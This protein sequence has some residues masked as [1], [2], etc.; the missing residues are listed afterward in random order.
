MNKS[1]L[2]IPVIFLFGMLS[3]GDSGDEPIVDTF[4]RTMLLKNV[5]DSLMIPSFENFTHKVSE[6]EGAASVFNETPSIENL[7]ALRGQWLD[8]YMAWQHVSLFDI[9]KADEIDFREKTNLY[10][11]N[12]EAIEINI[13]SSSINLDLP[14]TF[15][16]QG[17]P[18][19][20]YLL[21]LPNMDDETLVSMY[22]GIDG[23][24]RRE[25]LS[26]LISI[27]VN[28]CSMILADWNQKRTEWILDAGNTATSLVN[29]LVNDYIL[30]YEKYIRTAKVG[31]PA[32]V[33]SNNVLPATTEAF[34]SKENSK[35]LLIE[36]LRASKNFFI[37]MH[38]TNGTGIEDYLDHLYLESG[39]TDVKNLI[40]SQYGIIFESLM[41]VGDN[42]S[43]QVQSDNVAMLGL[44]DAMQELVVFIKTDMTARLNVR[45]DFVDT[46]G[47]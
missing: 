24:G 45:I 18:A 14:S 15:D 6:L 23:Q 44:F 20:D 43:T 37:G 10:P 47:D 38:E 17:F 28:N 32:G 39:G 30:H 29:L 31:I 12:T 11:T 21:H 13:A 42:F 16:Q 46:D 33:F 9:G 22:Q 3:C 41:N 36:A 40:L 7:Q 25:Y 4:D 35:T 2:L 1:I 5:V 19:I 8:S 26:S 27:L 34:F